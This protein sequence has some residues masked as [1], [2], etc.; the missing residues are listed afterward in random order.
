MVNF[1]SDEIDKALITLAI[2]R[3]LLDMSKKAYEE[4]GNRLY[5]KHGCYFMDCLEHPEY[6]TEILKEIFGNSST[7]I[8]ESI[9]NTL[10]ESKDKKTISRFLAQ[11]SE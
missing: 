4:V 11:I 9:K 7:L 10:H 6:L 3:T 2:E 5:K 8:V 1:N